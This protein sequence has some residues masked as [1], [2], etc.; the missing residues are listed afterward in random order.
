MVVT[1]L[2]IVSSLNKMVRYKEKVKRKLVVEEEDSSTVT[3]KYGV[4]FCGLIV[5]SS[6]I[7]V[8]PSFAKRRYSGGMISYD[9]K[10]KGR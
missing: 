4:R 8:P 3:N 2:G 1:H 9:E 5:S 6:E 10:G 7:G